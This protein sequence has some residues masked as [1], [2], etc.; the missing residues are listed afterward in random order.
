MRRPH[1]L[2]GS[3]L[4]ARSCRHIIP[5]GKSVLLGA[6]FLLVFLLNFGSG[7]Y[8]QNGV[9]ITSSENN[10]T[11]ANPIPIDV[12]FEDGVDELSSLDFDVTNGTILNI[13]REDPDFIDEGQERVLENFQV[14]TTKEEIIGA[15]LSNNI[16]GYL[17]EKLKKTV[18]SIDFNGNDELFY[19]TLNDGIFKINSNGNVDRVIPANEFDSPLDMVINRDND[20]IYVADADKGQVLIFNSSYSLIKT[21]GTGSNADSN[22]PRG[23]TGLALDDEGNIYVA[24]NF[25]GNTANQD[26]IK[27]Y[28]PNGNII[29]KISTY[30]GQQIEDPYRIAVDKHGNIYVSE[31]GGNQ[32]EPRIIIYDKDYIP[33]KVIKG[34]EQGNPGSLVVDDYGYLYAIDYEDDF[35]LT[36][37]FNDPLEVLG[38]Y[39]KIRD[40]RYTVNVFDTNQ[41]FNFVKE[42]DNSDLN[43]PIDLAIDNCGL[44]YI[45]NLRLQGAAPREFFTYP[46]LMDINF[47]FTLKKVQRKDNFIV[48]IGPKAPGLV[49]LV[50]EDADLFKCGPQPVGDFSIVYQLEEEE[51]PPL[52]IDCPGTQIEI[53]DENCRF[54]V[55]DYTTSMAAEFPEAEFSQSPKPGTFISASTPVSILAVMGEQND[56]CSFQLNL[57]DSMAPEINCPDPKTVTFDPEVGFTI[58]DYRDEVA[59]SDNCTSEEELRQ[60]LVQTP[61]PGETFYASQQI[62]FSVVDASENSHSCSFELTLEEEVPPLD[63]DCPGTQNE[64]LDENC[65]FEVPDYTTSMAAEFPEAEFSQSPKPGTFI[66][67]STPVS[68]SAVMGEQNDS[69]SFQL[70]LED[71]IAPEIK[72]SASKT[73]TFDPEVGFTVPDYRDEVAVSDNCT[74]EEELKQNLVQTPAPGET[75]YASRQIL[76]SVEDASENSHSCSFKLNLTE[77]QPNSPA[78]KCKDNQVVLDSFYEGAVTAEWFYDGD[79]ETDGVTLALNRYELTCEDLGETDLQLTITDETTGAFTTCTITAKVID[80]QKPVMNC[81]ANITSGFPVTEGYEVPD[82]STSY[83]ATDNCPEGLTYEQE[84]APGTMIFEEGT[85]TITMVA[86][87]AS[88]NSNSCKFPLTLVSLNLIDIT[89]PEN[90]VKELAQDCRF[91]VPDYTDEVQVSNPNAI[92][93]QTPLPGTFITESTEVVMTA[94]LNGETASCSFQ[95]NLTDK[96]P[97]IANCV[98]NYTLYLNEEGSAVLSVPMIDNN[99]TDNC[100]IESMSLSKTQFTTADIGEQDITLTVRDTFGNIDDCTTTITVRPYV[101]PGENTPPQARQDSYFT[102]INTTLSVPEEE[103]LLLNDNDID[104]DELEVQL[105]SGVSNGALTLESDGSFTYVPNEDFVGQDTFLYTVFDGEDVS[106]NALVTI[107]VLANI[108]CPDPE[109]FALDENGEVNLTLSMPG[110]FDVTFNVEQDYFTCADIGTHTLRVDYSGDFNGTCFVEVTIVDDLPPQVNCVSGFDLELD[111]DGN[112]TLTAEDLGIVATDNCGVDEISLSR[113][114]FGPADIG[115]QEVTVT[116]TDFSGNE[117]ECLTTITVTSDDFPA[118]GL[119]CVGSVTLPLNNEGEAYLFPEDLLTSNEEVPENLE[120][121][122]SFFTCEDIGETEVTLTANYTRGYH[123]SCTVLLTITDPGEFCTSIPVDPNPSEDG[124]YVIIYPNPGKGIVNVETSEGINLLRAEVFDMR[125]R[126]VFEK[127]FYAPKNNS[128]LDT[129]VDLRMYESGVYTI[130]YY[131]GEE[132]QYIRRAIINPD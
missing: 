125:G 99:S 15:A 32:R 127:D 30:N 96:I 84:P 69:C 7:V 1:A 20:N 115:E 8:A 91:E 92:V 29:K 13:L 112:A 130:I 85:Y 41:D 55:P 48:E 121:S 83:P 19:L 77:E 110:D 37:L 90:Q 31:S 64:I 78:P 107:N 71:T 89:C 12:Q 128:Q 2:P 70:N 46:A 23:A 104:D 114:N 52:D 40:S 124:E 66:S 35:N 75:I 122:R 131:S 58:P 3:F 95:L 101:A 123:E 60:N 116:V 103:G 9:T 100:S 73:V 94:N 105:I 56:S 38:N 67:A 82:F 49:E 98:S 36:D 126:F 74:S 81:P 76:F 45:N 47:D 14:K 97:P 68:I 113:T 11:S 24:D 21:I 54:E 10:P 65:R 63:I 42:F 22:N 120:L 39:E 53:L 26:A 62:S 18:V 93:T 108:D 118:P 129:A 61:A 86:I 119:S 17:L 117:A 4:C 16:Q 87:D 79:P 27:I 44:I 59:V 25:T 72:C 102:Q 50:L 43:L 33:I 51:V 106:N 6:L 88:G 34:G 132:E 109:T 111:E 57:E 28:A 80:G 5:M